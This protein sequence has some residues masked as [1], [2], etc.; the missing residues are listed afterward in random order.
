MSI[1]GDFHTNAAYFDSPSR[2]LFLE[3]NEGL[4]TG[5]SLSPPFP[6]AFHIETDFIIAV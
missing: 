4:T 5:I 6:M 1:A 2:S 3:E